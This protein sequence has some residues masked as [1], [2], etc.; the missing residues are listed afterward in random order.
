M[1][2]N[3]QDFDLLY[4]VIG[5]EAGL[6]FLVQQKSTLK[7]AEVTVRNDD[8]TPLWVRALGPG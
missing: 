6:A 3:R 8:T 1:F 4:Q 7:L 5:I 2:I